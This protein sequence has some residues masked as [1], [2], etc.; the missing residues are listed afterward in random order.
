[1]SGVELF[2]DYL[3]D[4][5]HAAALIK[6]RRPLAFG[7][8]C[9]VISGV[10][11]FVAQALA[12][13][14]TFLAFSYSSCLLVVLGRLATGFVMAAVIHLILE[15]GSVQGSAA[16]LFIQFG[17]ADLAWALA[18][19]AALLS[20]LL[21][22]GSSWPATGLFFAIGMLSLVLKARGLQDTYRIHSG[23]AWLTLAIPY[24]A[25]V[26]T[27]LLILSLAIVGVVMQLF[28]AFG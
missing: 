27:G 9:F 18:V 25:V 24:V 28:K 13:K 4:H 15:M 21:F 10:S 5:V 6:E 26:V 3:E 22:P 17:L 12:Q 8:L 7:V 23:R 19:P 20:R 16:S 1:M 11:L 14:L 2:Y